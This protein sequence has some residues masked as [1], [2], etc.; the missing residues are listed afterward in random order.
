MRLL[1]EASINALR[2][3]LLRSIWVVLCIA[4][5][6]LLLAWPSFLNRGP[7]FIA[8]TSAYLRS[9][10][11]AFSSVLSYD[12]I[13][14]DKR[15]LYIDEQRP[16]DLT[17]A[18]ALKSTTLAHPPLIGRSIY[19][20]AAIYGPVLFL[21]EHVGVLVQAA[22]SAIVVWLALIPLGLAHL[23]SRALSYFGAIGLLAA[24]TS[25]P[26]SAALLVPDYLT[27]LA[28]CA[29][30]LLVC[31][32]T[33]FTKWELGILVA[34][35]A[36]ATL[37][38]SSNLPLLLGLSLLALVVRFKAPLSV[39][40]AFIGLACVGL[41]F[42]GDAIFVSAVEKKTG[43]TP[44]RPPFLTARLIADGPGHKL[45]R[46][47]CPTQN[48]E[49]CRYVSRTPHDSDLFL[50][51]TDTTGVFSV[52]DFVSQQKLSE[53]DMKFAVATFHEYPLLTMASSGEA[54]VRQL[55]MLDLRIWRGDAGGKPFFSVAALPPAVA[56]R[57]SRTQSV[58]GVF[59]VQLSQALIE[60]MSLTAL[61]LACWCMV[62]AWRSDNHAVRMMGLA[63][64]LV[65]VAIIANAA[66]AGGLSKPDARY[67][68]RAIWLLPLF[69]YLFALQSRPGLQRKT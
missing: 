56:E 4:M 38:H 32:W 2:T 3:R 35:L 16:N 48:F 64:A 20:G 31:F 11:A 21:G 50:W 44:I 36:F 65:I 34:V 18:D 13:W 7:F 25:L 63:L 9:A 6:T 61:V 5:A 52:G 14:S 23:Q 60:I 27:G 46:A 55:G 49:V 17:K 37:S 29:F 57:M 39:K 28:C 59:P 24:L 51:S 26:F 33:I 19:Y 8:D 12:S 58:A 30:V 47:R 43:M 69:V 22:L 62:R 67:N 40:A 10:D 54:F 66:I 41:G 45:L 1:T 53:Q 68:L 15:D 42:L